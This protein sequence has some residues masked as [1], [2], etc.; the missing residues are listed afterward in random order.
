MY[1]RSITINTITMIAHVSINASDFEKAKGFYSKALAPLGYTLIKD[2]AEWQVAGYGVG[3]YADTW[4]YGMGCKQP[5]HIA[6]VA[7]SKEEVDAFYKAA[8]AAGAKD[9]GS[10]EYCTDYAPGYYAGFVY[11]LDGNNIEAVFIDTSKK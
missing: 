7:K 4:V 9:N 8:I 3:E 11:D 6:Y 10:P 1:N 2:L 5:S